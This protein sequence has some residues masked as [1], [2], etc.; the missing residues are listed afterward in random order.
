VAAARVTGGSTGISP[1]HGLMAI[2]TLS[3]AKTMAL[4]RINQ[5]A[6]SSW[7]E[8]LLSA[9]RGSARGASGRML[10]CFRTLDFRF[11]RFA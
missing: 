8:Y 11:E 6:Y 1:R 7:F 3:S 2:L 4:G 10:G 5:I 9:I